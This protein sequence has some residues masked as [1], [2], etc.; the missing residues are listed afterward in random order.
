MEN[1]IVSK[2]K[3]LLA[4]AEKGGT[5]AE[6]NS[7]MAKAQE[8]LAKHGLSME[9]IDEFG[10]PEKVERDITVSYTAPWKRTIW[11]AISKLYFCQAYHTGGQKMYLVGKPSNIAIA[12]YIIGYCINTGEKLAKDAAKDY[13]SGMGFINSFKKGFGGRIYTRA[14]AE[15]EKAKTG[16]ITDTVTGN[17]LIVHPLYTQA[18]TEVDVF[19]RT[20]GIRLSSS[21]SQSGPRNRDGYI[22]GANAANGISLRANAL[23]GGSANRRIGN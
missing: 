16:G 13:P 3:K 2:I 9:A 12:K 1:S 19:M 14:M 11:S 23:S 22:V 6:A 7:A 10:A 17:Q 15:I 5:E 18:K 21:S 4:L 20:A 8:L